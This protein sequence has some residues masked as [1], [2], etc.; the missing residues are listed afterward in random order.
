MHVLR[1][2]WDRNEDRVIVASA[3]VRFAM[4][5]LLIVAMGAAAWGL[6][7]LA[8]GSRSVMRA[9]TRSRSWRVKVH[10]NGRAIWR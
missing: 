7:Y 6:T 4:T 8:G 3:D 10:S 9:R 5:V 2:W 1:D